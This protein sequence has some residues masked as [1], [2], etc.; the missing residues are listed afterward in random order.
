MINKRNKNKSKFKMNEDVKNAQKKIDKSQKLQN[1]RTKIHLQRKEK[2]GR[3]M[4]ESTKYPFLSP[5]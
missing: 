5:S 4:M 3:K 2:K 1:Q